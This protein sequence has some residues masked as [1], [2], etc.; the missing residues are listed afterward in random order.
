MT[1]LSAALLWLMLLSLSATVL[2]RRPWLPGLV[3]AVGL[4]LLAWQ[5]W[6]TPVAGVTTIFGREIN[7]EQANSFLGFTLQLDLVGRGPALLMAVWGALFALAAVWMRGDRVLFP[8]IPLILAAFYLALST[9]P[10]LWAP[11]WLVVAA[12][13][14]TFPAQGATPRRAAAALRLLAAPTLAFPLFLFA[15][16]VLGQA[17]LA[18]DDPGLWVNGWRA[19]VIGL[20]LLLTPVPLHGWIVGQ[21]EQAP[22]FAAAFQVGV[23]QIAVYALVRRILLSYPAVTDYVDPARVLPWLAIILMVW[24]AWFGLSSG[25]LK[26]LWGYLLLYD[27][28]AAFLLWGFSGE[29]GAQA[30]IWMFLARPFVLIVIAAGLQMLSTRFGENPSYAD[31]HGGAERLPLTTLALVGG[32]LFLLGWPLGAL[33]PIRLSVLRLVQTNQTGLAS[34]GGPAFLWTMLAL[35]FITLAVLRALRA[36]GRPLVDPELPREDAYLGWLVLPLLLIGLIL[37]LNPGVLAPV[38]DRVSAWMWSF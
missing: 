16:W 14:M 35:L 10:L 33:F 37:S 34:F 17:A 38:V 31:L 6:R 28:G 9:T 32:G 36:L 18:E 29:F 3:I 7:V 19:L 22:P 15:A 21:G 20:G 2:R 25:R 4:A 27:F 23:W 30:M 12:I 24:A 5:L 11:I 26:Q 8:A 13:F 1:L